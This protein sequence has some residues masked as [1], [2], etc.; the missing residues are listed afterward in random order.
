M[1]LIDLTP[2]D[3]IS[4]YG[5]G[6]LCTLFFLI[7]GLMM[8]ITK[9]PNLISKKEQYKNEELLVLL[10]GWINIVFSLIMIAILVIAFIKTELNLTLFLLLGITVIT[11]LLMQFMLQLKFKKDK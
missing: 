2:A 3:F 6:F 9:N 5:L 1:I 10:Y 4:L 7:S 11:A 8:V